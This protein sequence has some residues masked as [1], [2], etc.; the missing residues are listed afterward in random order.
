[1]WEGSKKEVIPTWWTIQREIV[2]MD[3]GG[4]I[5]SSNNICIH[6]LE[7]SLTVEGLI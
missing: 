2:Q 4:S 7:K 1:M 5:S 6:E 3:V